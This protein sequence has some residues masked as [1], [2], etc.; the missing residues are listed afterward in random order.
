MINCYSVKI[1]PIIITYSGNQGSHIEH[2]YEM[3]GSESSTDTLI[4]VCQ[5]KYHSEIVNH[6]ILQSPVS[7]RTIFTLE[8]LIAKIFDSLAFR[9]DACSL[10]ADLMI[11]PI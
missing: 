3:L 2:H 5:R 4:L 7:G 1:E 8:L 9:T 6:L 11:E 10:I